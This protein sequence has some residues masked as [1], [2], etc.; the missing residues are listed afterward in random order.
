[1]AIT[2][3]EKPGDFPA[4]K[5]KID[6]NDYPDW[7]IRTPL[8]GNAG[9][10]VHHTTGGRQFQI[11]NPSRSK[12][13]QQG[14]DWDGNFSNNEFVLYTWKRVGPIM[15]VFDVPVRGVG[16]HVQENFGTGDT[17][18]S[19]FM[20]IIRVFGSSHNPLNLP[21]PNFGE[22]PGISD[23]GTSHK[24]PFVGVLSDTANIKFVEFDTRAVSPGDLD[25]DFA[26]GRVTIIA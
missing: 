11:D 24:A 16:A 6:W 7:V 2:F 25:G 5:D 15:I 10:N 19:H 9:N 8:S 1:M 13:M 12:I 22:V 18:G 20:G 17:I 3:I 23:D 4:P 14:S 26:V 21:G